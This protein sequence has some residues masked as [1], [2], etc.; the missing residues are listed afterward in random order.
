MRK[1]RSFRPFKRWVPKADQTSRPGRPAGREVEFLAGPNS[2]A[3]IL[4]EYIYEESGRRPHTFKSESVVCQLGLPTLKF[5]SVKKILVHKFAGYEYV[6]LFIGW[7]PPPKCDPE[8]R[9][10]YSANKVEQTSPILVSKAYQPLVIA[11][12]GEFIWFQDAPISGNQ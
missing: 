4:R 2:T 7:F 12:E 8:S 6:W 3:T 1:L 5:G 11:K 9:I 10:L